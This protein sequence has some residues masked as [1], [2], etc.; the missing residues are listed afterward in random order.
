MIWET[1]SLSMEFLLECVHFYYTHAY[2][3]KSTTH[4]TG[5]GR[6]ARNVSLFIKHVLGIYW[7]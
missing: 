5:I 6:N 3:L 4:E 1:L 7:I 2:P